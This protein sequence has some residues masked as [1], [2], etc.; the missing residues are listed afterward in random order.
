MLYSTFTL[1]EAYNGN[2]EIVNAY[3]T[4]KSIENYSSDM[5]ND[6]GDTAVLGMTVGLFALV[7][8]LSL[9]FWI[10]ALVLT[11]SRWDTLPD[12][13]KVLCIWGLFAPPGP[14][15]TLIIAHVAKK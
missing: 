4:G 3:L 5:A 2:K 8:I 15:L 11:I 12:W 7:L 13:G 14:L 1:I 10:W 6:G 9:A